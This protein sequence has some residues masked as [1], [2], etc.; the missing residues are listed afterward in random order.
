MNIIDRETGTVI[1][2]VETNHSMTIEEALECAGYEYV[3][4]DGQPDLCGYYPGGVTDF[5]DPIDPE[6][7]DMDYDD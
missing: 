6:E 7:C 1:C 3:N 2:H 5:N 4:W